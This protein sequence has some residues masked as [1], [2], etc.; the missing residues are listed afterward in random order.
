ACREAHPQ[1][2]VKLIAYDARRG[3]QTTALSFIVGRPA[4][5]PGLSVERA[6]I[7]DRVLRYRLAPTR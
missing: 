7:H 6:D 2:Y 4:V 1:H 5:E 3:R